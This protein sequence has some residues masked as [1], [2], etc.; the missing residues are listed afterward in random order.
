[1]LAP[2]VSL[3]WLLRFSLLAVVFALSGFAEE[4]ASL[5]PAQEELLRQIPAMLVEPI[6]A[7]AKWVRV[8]GRLY[9]DT[10][11][12]EF[13]GWLLATEKDR[14]ILR[15]Y[16]GRKVVALKGAYPFRDPHVMEA[17][18]GDVAYGRATVEPRDWA[19]EARTFARLRADPEQ[20]RRDVLR[21]PNTWGQRGY[22]TGII[23]M[24]EALVAAWSFQR[25]DRASAAAILL[26]CYARTPDP[27][28]VSSEVRRLLGRPVEDRL[29]SL[30][31]ERSFAAA[32]PLAE[33]LASPAFAGYEGQPLARELAAQLA[34]RQDENEP[35]AL[36]EDAEWAKQKAALDRPAQIRFL[37]GRLRFL[38]Q[39]YAM[40]SVDSTTSMTYS[41]AL[42]DHSRRAINPYR[43]LQA[44]DLGPK[45]AAELLPFL[46]DEDYMPTPGRYGFG[47]RAV[48]RGEREPPAWHR[49]HWVVAELINEIAYRELI[50]LAAWRKMNASARAPIVATVRQWI[51]QNE[52]RTA[53]AHRLQTIR[54]TDTWKTFR[55]ASR[56]AIARHQ[57]GIEPEIA[58]RLSKFAARQSEEMA[59]LCLLTP[60]A[61]VLPYARDWMRDTGDGLR[62]W[63]A[64]GFLQSGSSAEKREALTVLAPILERDDGTRRYPQAFE[65]LSNAGDPEALDLAATILKK[66]VPSNDL[67]RVLQRLFLRGRP[68]ALAELL[69]RF[70]ST[71][72]AGQTSFKRDGKDITSDYTEA[73]AVGW[74]VSRW[75]KTDR[76]F[77]PPG[78]ASKA[79][80]EAQKKWL[81]EQFALVKAGA[82][83]AI[84]EPG[85][86]SPARR[87]FWDP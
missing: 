27:G 23:S 31:R 14:Y 78:T 87:V 45:D 17:F 12:S 81:Q 52:D 21:P 72:K 4:P 65:I 35:I 66:P 55:S 75:Q 36:P 37:A 28:A 56:H 67:D 39:V 57:S 5:T 50:D 19:R 2:M 48:F 71:K 74:L 6:P 18:G 10:R 16:F 77:L 34:R 40:Q 62:F 32:L 64:L 3:R 82:K 49:V 33:L 20:M 9:D 51:Q 70:G 24:P 42:K 69:R 41:L 53:E 15:D 8:T 61:A 79:A 83:P 59:E 30:F 7:T 43:E 13:S 84:D 80:R 22:Q 76:P 11:P 86:I 47:V 26:P 60:N 38:S 54:S 63:G 29:L 46:A 44:L 1:M 85:L 73:D 68:E 25:G 58:R